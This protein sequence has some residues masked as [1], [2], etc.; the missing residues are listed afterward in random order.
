MRKPSGTLFQSWFQEHRSRSGCL[1][2]P[3]YVLREGFDLYYI[4]VY[5]IISIISASHSVRKITRV[6]QEESEA[7]GIPH[8]P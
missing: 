2:I 5:V 8:C 6:S 1:R 3:R 4:H 7:A